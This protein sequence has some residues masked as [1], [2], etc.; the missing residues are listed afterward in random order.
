[1]IVGVVQTSPQFGEKEINR[2]EIE[3]LIGDQRADLWIVP[4][5]ALTGYEFRSRDEAIELSEEIPSGE[6]ARWIAEFCSERRCHAVMGIAERSGNR[7]H[8]SAIVVGPR[9]YMGRY[10]KIHL[11]DRERERFDPGDLPL[12]VFDLGLARVGVM[13]C[14]DWRFPE[15]SRT[16]T[17]MGAQ[18]LAHPSN[19]VLSH[20]PAA[21]VTRAL[22]NRV[23]TATADRIGTEDRAGEKVTFFGGSCIV[24]PRGEQ[25]SVAPR[26]ESAVLIAEVD[27][28][29]ADNKMI[30]ARNDLLADRRP[31]F[32]LS[33][34]P[35]MAG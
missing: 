25:L 9:G 24:S 13:I 20:C 2:R 5:L 15:V 31:E 17:L 21:M 29:L 10:R 8:N 16:L 7:V 30:N 1:M 12:Q 28:A 3:K 35:P 27:P 6:S 26:A 33:E 23:F 14:Y 11:F 18:I 22:E 32:Y 4:E 19:L 34:V